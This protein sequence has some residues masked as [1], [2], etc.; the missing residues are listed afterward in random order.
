MGI[1]LKYNLRKWCVGVWN[2][3]MCLKIGPLACTTM[4][5][6]LHKLGMY[7][8]RRLLASQRGLHCGP[9]FTVL[10][11][12]L[13]VAL[14]HHSW[15]QKSGEMFDYIGQMVCL[16]RCLTILGKWF[17]WWHVW[18]YWANGLTGEMFDYTGQMV[19]LVRCLTILGKCLSGEMFDN[20]GQIVCLVRCLTIMDKWFVWWDVWLY[21]ANVLSGEMFD[22][23]GQ[24]VCLVRCFTILGKWFPAFR[25]A[26]PWYSRSSRR[27][28]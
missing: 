3:F 4:N 18:L 15:R 13:Q 6:E 17:V 11:L 8:W 7:Y 12:M 16:L 26:V 1:I 23:I 22:Y 10:P 19:F 27:W 28:R 24:I 2:G 9:F 5:P 25:T 21:W 14:T 20:I